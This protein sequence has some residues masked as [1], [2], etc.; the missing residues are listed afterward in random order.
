MGHAGLALLPMDIQRIDL[1]GGYW[2]E[3]RGATLDAGHAKLLEPIEISLSALTAWVRRQ[4][5]E[6]FA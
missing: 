4:L 1:D 6:V 2:L 3:R 5:R